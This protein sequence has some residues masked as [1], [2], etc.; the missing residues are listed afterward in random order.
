MS[1]EKCKY[2]PEWHFKPSAYD[3]SVDDCI[4]NTIYKMT[5]R[6]ECINYFSKI[7]P[8]SCSVKDI[9]AICKSSDSFT[10]TDAKSLCRALTQAEY[11]WWKQKK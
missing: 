5:N 3:K 1:E 11:E 2:S 10:L 7:A 4:S 9:D 8:A 6:D